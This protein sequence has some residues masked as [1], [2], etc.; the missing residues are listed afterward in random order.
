MSSCAIAIFVKTPGYS[1]IKT[2]LARELGEEEALRIYRSLLTIVEESVGEAVRACRELNP[3]W[4]VAEEDA[5]GDA[6]WQSFPTID[7]GTGGLGTRL[8]K[9][10]AELLER[11]DRVLLIGADCPLLSASVLV[12]AAERIQAKPQPQ[13]VIGPATDGG[14]YL[15]GGA[16]AI[17]SSVWEG[18]SYSSSSTA[19][20][21]IDR[22]AGQGL[23]VR[24]PTL[25]DVDTVDDLEVLRAPM[26]R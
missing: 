5:L 19:S 7:Q 16:Q 1:P 6:L 10:Y 8:H 15:F 26:R 9:V 20:E 2:R 24:L 22:L 14:F 21:L 17:A 25:S 4:A 3:Y 18:V 23:V 13:F 12:S 11:F